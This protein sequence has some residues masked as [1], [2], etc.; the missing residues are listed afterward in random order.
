M[1]EKKLP[2]IN[3]DWVYNCQEEYSLVYGMFPH[4]ILCVI[5]F[6]KKSIIVNPHIFNCQNAKSDDLWLS[7]DQSNFCKK[8]KNQTNYHHGFCFDGKNLSML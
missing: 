5:D 2:I 1:K 6:C 4:L 3:D 7:I 8:L